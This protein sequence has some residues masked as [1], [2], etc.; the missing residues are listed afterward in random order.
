MRRKVLVVCGI[1][2]SVLHV[3]R[4]SLGVM[5]WKRD[6][7]TSQTVSELLATGLPSTRLV[8]PLFIVSSVLVIASRSTS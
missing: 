2:T 6:T 7:S 4:A 1:V 5:R 3:A 8:V